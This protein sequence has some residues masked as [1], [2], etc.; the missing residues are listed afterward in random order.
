MIIIRA[1]ISNVTTKEVRI[2]K[3][4]WIDVENCSWHSELDIKDSLEQRRPRILPHW[5]NLDSI[6]LIENTFPFASDNSIPIPRLNFHNPIS[7]RL[8]KVCQQIE[9]KYFVYCRAALGEERKR[10]CNHFVWMDCWLLRLE[11]GLGKRKEKKRR[12]L[13]C[14]KWNLE[15]LSWYRL[16]LENAIW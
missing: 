11:F 12:R 8:E 10:F 7:A 2:E 6:Y 15:C 16:R 14:E 9:I 3:S 4:N 13:R 1:N 5:V